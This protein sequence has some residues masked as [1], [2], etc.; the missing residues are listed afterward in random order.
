[1]SDPKAPHDDHHD[2]HDK[3]EEEIIKTPIWMPFVGIGLLL[4]GSIFAYSKWF[5]T[6]A[7]SAEIVKSD[8]AV[9]APPSP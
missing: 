1:M 7:P 8:A 2:T 4:F 9:Q 3:T 6:T 5:S